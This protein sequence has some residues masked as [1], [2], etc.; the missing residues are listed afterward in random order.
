[1]GRLLLL[2]NSLP[3]ALG[4]H[5]QEFLL[6]TIL[7]SRAVG[8]EDRRTIPTAAA[9]VVERVDLELVLDYL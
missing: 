4:L 2:S 7:L 9:V 1:M 8:E 6:L 5:Q 3:L